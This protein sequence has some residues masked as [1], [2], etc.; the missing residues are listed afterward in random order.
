LPACRGHNAK[1]DELR[2]DLAD[3]NRDEVEAAVKMLVEE[4]ESL[5]REAQEVF[6]ARDQAVW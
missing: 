5:E 2:A 3:L 1:K 6:A 4:E